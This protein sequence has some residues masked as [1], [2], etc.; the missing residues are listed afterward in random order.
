MVGYVIEAQLMYNYHNK[1]RSLQVW[2]IPKPAQEPYLW[3]IIIY[4]YI[5]YKRLEAWFAAGCMETAFRGGQTGGW[6]KEPAVRSQMP[7]Q[8]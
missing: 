2:C 6:S 5:I 8:K 1:G 4:V 7:S 3:G